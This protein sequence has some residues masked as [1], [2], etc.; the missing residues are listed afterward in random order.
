MTDVFTQAGL[1]KRQLLG[2]GIVFVDADED[3]WPDLMTANGHVYPEVDRASVGDRY[4]QQTLLFR[5]LGT[6]TF[7]DV[8]AE[9]GPALQQPRSAR[10]MAMGDL[11]G[12][13]HPEI[14]VVNMNE[15]PALLRNFGVHRH[16][17]VAS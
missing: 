10:G 13:G 12:D 2:W 16:A 5:N 6:G 9:A 4:R 3:G 1:N 8:T 11:D 15:P 7:A 14:V 17:V